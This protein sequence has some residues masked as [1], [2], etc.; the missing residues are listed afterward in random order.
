MDLQYY[1]QDTVENQVQMVANTMYKDETL[2]QAFGLAGSIIFES[3]TNL[4]V[5]KQSQ[6]TEKQ[7]Q[8]LS[9]DTDPFFHKDH[10]IRKQKQRAN[11][12]SPISRE[13]ADQSYIYQQGTKKDISAIT[14]EYKAPHKLTCD[15]ITTGLK[16]EMHPARDVINRKKNTSKFYFKYLVIVVITQLFSYMVAKDMQYS[17]VCTEKVFIFLYILKNPSIIK[18]AICVPNQNV[19]TNHNKDF[20]LT[21]VGQIIGFT[22]Q[23]LASPPS[24]QTWHAV[25]SKLSICLVEYLE[26]LAQTPS[27]KQL[28]NYH[29]LSSI[30][31]SKK[32]NLLLFHMQLW[33]CQPPS[34]P[35]SNQFPSPPLSDSSSPAHKIPNILKSQSG[36]ESQDNTS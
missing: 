23:A 7:T 3:H 19:Q 9:T 4:R 33:S 28:K 31:Y 16:E 22:M 21:A 10:T 17:Y 11:K 8:D 1:K 35:S 15:K 29:S 26:I 6:V 13:Q 32:I 34:N 12:D 2:R 27:N 18:Y 5:S 30:Y 36:T 25:V 14:I 24:L 20:E